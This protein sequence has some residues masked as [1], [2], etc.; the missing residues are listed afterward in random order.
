MIKEKASSGQSSGQNS[1]LQ[2]PVPSPYGSGLRRYFRIRF[3]YSALKYLLA[4]FD[5][6]LI[7]VSSLVGGGFY[8]VLLSGDPV[9]VQTLMGVGATAALLYALIGQ[10]TGFYDL[11][12]VLS[13][14]KRDG[15][16]V[17]ALWCLVSLVLTL[18]AFLL[19]AGAIFSRGSIICFGLLALSLLLT[20][21]RPSKQLAA[22]LVASGQVQG[23]R[24]VLLGTREEL[25]ALGVGELLER[26]GLTEI[27]RVI[28]GVDGNHSFALNDN[29]AAS[30]GAALAIARERRV[31]EIVLALPWNDTRK[32]ELIRAGLR[33]SPLPVQLLPDRR[34]RSL[35]GNPAFRLQETLSLEIQR[36]PLSQAEQ[37][38]KR[39][40]D[41]VGATVGLVLLAPLMFIAALAIKLDSSGPIFFLQRR[42]G[43]N[44]KQFAIFKFR[45]MRV[46]EDG[47]IVVQA[48]RSD[49][50]VTRVG[51]ILRETSI[52]EVPQL[53]NVLR[54]EMSLVG[55]RPHAL[56]HDSHY[57]DL[58]A[59]YAFRH[60]VKP[61]ITGWAQVR[62]YRGE[63]SRVE[64]MKGRVDCDLWYINNWNLLLDLRIILM[65]CFA[66]TRRKNAY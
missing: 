26:F 62:G 2:Q 55:P 54:G 49:P 47:P 8:Q 42:N 60:H 41:I 58:L 14:R 16:R 22:S 13:I 43:F 38:S 39:L 35:A 46:M 1:D 24:A 51:R 25:A 61:G 56:A 3:P 12:I 44:A 64:Q 11:R 7:V 21:R 36:G 9:Q 18:L 6:S 17:I 57:G 15:G 53:L 65:T 23:R 29:E 37:F 48:T 20:F 4:T 50:R 63:T 66:L 27:E 28:L 45:T 19:K 34:I 10:A 33:I 30:L 31:D 52:D 59:D 32:I 40:L 5:V